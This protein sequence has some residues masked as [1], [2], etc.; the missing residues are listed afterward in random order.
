MSSKEQDKEEETPKKRFDDMPLEEL[1]MIAYR[2]QIMYKPPLTEDQREE[3]VS[4]IYWIRNNITVDEKSRENRMKE[5][6]ERR[7]KRGKPCNNEQTSATLKDVNLM[8][9]AQLVFLLDKDEGKYYCFDR[10]ED[11]PMLLQTK[12]NPWNTKKLTKEQISYLEGVRDNSKYPKIETM[13]FFDEYEEIFKGV[14]GPVFQEH[15]YKEKMRKLADIIASTGKSM[16]YVSDIIYKFGSE[17]GLVNYNVF[18]MHN[19]IDKTVTAGSTRDNAAA[20]ALQIILNYLEVRKQQG[21]LAEA[22]VEI[23]IAIDEFIYYVTNKLNYKQLLEERGKF[24]NGFTKE[25]LWKPNFLRETYYPNSGM[26]LSRYYV[27][28]NINEETQEITYTPYGDVEYFDENTGEVM[29]VN[30]MDE[31]GRKQGEW[32]GYDKYGNLQSYATYK[33]GE[34]SDGRIMFT[35]NEKKHLDA[36]SIEDFNRRYEENAVIDSVTIIGVLL[37]GQLDGDANIKVTFHRRYSTRRTV[38][39][40]SGAYK[41]GKRTGYWRWYYPENQT[42]IGLYDDSG[43]LLYRTPAKYDDNGSV[44][45]TVPI[46]EGEEDPGYKEFIKL[47]FQ[48]KLMTR[49]YVKPNTSKKGKDIKIGLWTEY[50]ESGF[51]YSRTEYDEKGDLVSSVSF[52]KIR[53]QENPGKMKGVMWKEVKGKMMMTRESNME[54]LLKIYTYYD[55][56]GNILSVAGPLSKME[57]N[58][59]YNKVEN[60]DTGEEDLYISKIEMRNEYGEREGFYIKYIPGMVPYMVGNFKQLV[61]LSISNYDEYEKEKAIIFKEFEDKIVKLKKKID[62]IERPMRTRSSSTR[63]QSLKDK[64]EK[65]K[66]KRDELLENLRQ[67]YLKEYSEPMKTG[68]WIYPFPDAFGS[69]KL[70][71]YPGMEEMLLYTSNLDIEDVEDV[72]DMDTIVFN[73]DLTGDKPMYEIVG[74]LSLSEMGSFSKFS[75][76]R[77][78]YFPKR[79][80]KPKWFIPEIPES[81]MELSFEYTINYNDRETEFTVKTIDIY[82]P[83][84]KIYE[85]RFPYGDTR[86]I[87]KPSKDINL[88]E[89]FKTYDTEIYYTEEDKRT[90]EQIESEGYLV[91]EKGEIRYNT[92]I[93]V[94]EKY[95]IWKKYGL[96]KT[97]RMITEYDNLGIVEEQVAINTL[98]EFKAMKE[99]IGIYLTRKEYKEQLKYWKNVNVEDDEGE[100]SDE[101]SDD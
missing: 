66:N 6:E 73:V 9:N 36:V 42:K 76:C 75:V 94:P 101:E 92:I 54:E 41:N 34:L 100:E 35:S 17:M 25:L 37:N 16:S 98:E 61:N 85:K 65:Q 18:L 80:Y 5:W 72:D 79:E 64:I 23:G 99:S 86:L 95:G 58:V 4:N 67:K 7:L 70:E 63:I 3:V 32:R 83:D 8:S 56:D 50:D 15:P 91:K 20:E 39:Y 55:A 28:V 78:G 27:Q 53:D 29:H 12:R 45:F 10:I 2:L 87:V 69:E 51:I 62:V 43:L 90:K 21:L 31:E 46:K 74:V 84:G 97:L 68:V 88:Y 30:R 59:Y 93:G 52:R 13:D 1:E 96:D 71:L 82:N 26:V 44:T 19:P 14:S 89:Q 40:T 11:I 60:V 48:D 81:D 77:K 57:K 47:N 33:D 24:Y 49:G 22:A 38:N